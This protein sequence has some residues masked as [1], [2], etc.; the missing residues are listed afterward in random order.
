MSRSKWKIPFIDRDVY[1]YMLESKSKY[2][3][4]TYSRRSI[5]YPHLVG[6]EIKVHNGNSFRNVKINEDMVFH[7][8]GEFVPT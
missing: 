3:K 7:K 8:L 2:N 6:K 4:K 5:I 1:K